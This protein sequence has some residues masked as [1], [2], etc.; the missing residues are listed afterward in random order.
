MSTTTPTESTL[1]RAEGMRPSMA[2][3]RVTPRVLFIQKA[4]D[5]GERRRWP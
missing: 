5:W 1:R 2:G 3:G 4:A